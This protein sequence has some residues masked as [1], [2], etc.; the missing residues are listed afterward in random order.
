METISPD[1][2]GMQR[3]WDSKVIRQRAMAAVKRRVE[4]G[5]LWDIGEASQDRPDRRKIVGLVKRRQRNVTFQSRQHV[6]VDTDRLVVVQTSMHHAMSDGDWIDLQFVPQPRAR[7]H[8]RGRDVMD[9]S[10]VVGSVHQHIAFDRTD[11]QSRAA[12]DPIHL[13]LDLPFQTAVRVDPEDLHLDARRS[14]VGDEDGIHDSYAAT[15]V[16]ARRR[17]SA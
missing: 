4:A 6:F 11:E 1:S 14:C 9:G 8:E 13:A 16:E 17:A 10:V 2:F 5:N 3:E 15:T 12:S 7:C